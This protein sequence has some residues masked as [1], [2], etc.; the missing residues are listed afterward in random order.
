MAKLALCIGVN[1]YPGTG[2]DP[3]GCVN[4]AYDWAALKQ[5]GFD[6]QM[7]LNRQA[8]GEGIRKAIRAIVGEAKAGDSVVIQYSGH[9]SFVRDKDGDE[10]NG[11]DE[12]L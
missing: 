2:S 8:T 3:A 9:G 1:D 4:D 7:L 6:V 10:P 5:R 12:C 11:T